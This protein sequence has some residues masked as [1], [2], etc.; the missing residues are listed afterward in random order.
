[1]KWKV[2]VGA[3]QSMLA[4]A[5]SNPGSN[6]HRVITEIFCVRSRVSANRTN[7]QVVS[8]AIQCVR[9]LIEGLRNDFPGRKSLVALLL[10]KYKEKH[11]SVQTAVDAALTPSPRGAIP[12]TR[13]RRRSPL[14]RRTKS[15]VRLRALAFSG[16]AE[17]IVDKKFG[18]MYAALK[19]AACQRIIISVFEKALGD[20]NQ[21]VR[22]SA[23]A[24]FRILKRSEDAKTL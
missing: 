16:Y 2:K 17:N 24:G 3:L 9:A 12:S 15:D 4:I 1:M 5:K 14:R 23:L 22:A 19:K 8:K 13:L 20:A 10:S 18:S 7:V 11:R 21:K 6:R